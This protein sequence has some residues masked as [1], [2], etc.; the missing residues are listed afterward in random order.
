L[1]NTSGANDVSADLP[2]AP[3]RDAVSEPPAT[4][5]GRDDI[6]RSPDQRLADAG[7]ATR[8]ASAVVLAALAIAAAVLGNW[9]FVL[10]WAV[11]AVGVFWEWTS[12]AAG[13][14]IALLGVGSVALLCAA[15]AAGS[16]YFL[17]ALA[18]VLA[19]ALTVALLSEPRTRAWA[20]GG[21]FYAGTLLLGPVVLRR[22]PV[23][24]EDAILFLFAV[25]WAT[26]VFG[27]FAGR[28][29]GGP[30]LA[31]S[32]SPNKTLAG[33]GG[34]ALGAVAAGL[35]A[36]RSTGNVPLLTSAG[37]ALL[38]SA[39]SQGGDLFE[40][41]VKRRFG[42][43]DAGHA[44]PGHGG[45]MDRLDGFLAAAGVAALVGLA[46]GGTEASARGLLWW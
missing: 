21:V 40:S 23:L 6:A 15:A 37:L 25:V 1:P 10:F 41:A 29:L 38:L 13:H 30:K 45:L 31:A 44:I 42:V 18:A 32:I 12:I 26:D 24:G 22:D 35:V 17:L 33:A 20:I 11:A 34:G 46:H 16:G 2:L 28:A 39:V 4:D 43:K 27:Y 5:R 19:G 9:P 36:V 14:S 3:D 8:A 7:L